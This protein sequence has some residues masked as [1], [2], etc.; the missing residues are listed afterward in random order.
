MAGVAS[1]LAETVASAAIRILDLVCVTRSEIDGSLTVVE[2]E[3]VAAM[4]ALQ[5]AEGD[6]GGLLSEHDIE[7]ASLAVETGTSAILLLIEDRWAESLSKAAQQAGGRVAG[8]ERIARSRVE[9]ALEA[10]RRQRGPTP[11]PAGEAD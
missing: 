9:Q 10:L 5:Q 4:A 7:T 11:G 3:D 8:G 1:A 2:F 6:V